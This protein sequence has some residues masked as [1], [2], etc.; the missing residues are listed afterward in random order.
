MEPFTSIAGKLTDFFTGNR[1]SKSPHTP[2]EILK[3]LQREVFHDLMKLR[4]RQDKVEKILT[5]Y[6]ISKGSPFEDD[7]TRVRGAVDAMGTVFFVDNLDQEKVDVI[8]RTGLKTGIDARINFETKVRQGDILEAEFVSRQRNR[9]DSGDILASALSL[10]RVSYTAN[11]TDWLS[12]VAI[13][14]G[15]RCKDVGIST[16]FSLQERG[17]TDYS[18]FGPPL[19]Y[20]NHGSVIGVTVKKS[21]IVASLAQFVA[22]LPGSFGQCFS[23]F[24]QVVYHLPRASKLSLFGLY[25]VTKSGQQAHPG[26]VTFPLGI[27]R[28][29]QRPETSTQTSSPPLE[30]GAEEIV[31][32]GQLAVMLESELD[33]STRVRGWVQMRN[34]NPKHLQWSVS[35]SD[36]P[37][38][39]IGWGLSLG[40]AIQGP[41]SWDH[42]QVEAF[43]KFNLGRRLTLKPAFVYIVDGNNQIPA[44]MFHSTWSL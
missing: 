4:D 22:D 20:Q 28:R 26:V 39:E 27:W 17:T 33:E 41:K 21:N 18:S 11:M 24:G 34:S 8:K 44:L 31:P 2:I 14:M 42:F 6:S 3:R 35:V 7:G 16:D 9:G 10:T 1:R 15:A 23:T 5:S 32:S 43:L 19:L 38:D 29:D 30:I 40:G 37:E 36:F 12:M 25:P 13:P